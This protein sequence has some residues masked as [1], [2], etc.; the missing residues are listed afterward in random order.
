MK[1]RLSIY[2]TF[3][4]KDRLL[5]AKDRIDLPKDHFD[6]KMFRFE[7]R[8]SYIE[9]DTISRKTEYFFKMADI[10]IQTP[11]TFN[12]ARWFPPFTF[13]FLSV[14]ILWNFW[15]KNDQFLNFI[16][17]SDFSDNEYEMYTWENLN[18]QYS[19]YLRRASSTS[20][21]FP[22]QNISFWKFRF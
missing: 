8:E 3:N 4:V 10:S 16:K 14:K 22:T 19:W 9:S 17:I 6:W 15:P 2:R 18:R 11:F 12:Q 21:K 5:L 7:R 1:D 13:I 20:K